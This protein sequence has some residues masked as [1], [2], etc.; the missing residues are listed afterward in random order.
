VEKETAPFGRFAAQ[1]MKSAVIAPRRGG[2]L[3]ER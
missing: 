2:E 3:V 1:Q